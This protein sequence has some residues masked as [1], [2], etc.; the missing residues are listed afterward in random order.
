[1]LRQI[2]VCMCVCVC[3]NVC[4][5]CVS[6]MKIGKLHKFPAKKLE[7][8]FGRVYTPL[9][10]VPWIG[11]VSSTFNTHRVLFCHMA[12]TVWLRGVKIIEKIDIHPKNFPSKQ[13]HDRSHLKC[14]DILPLRTEHFPS[15]GPWKVYTS[16]GSGGGTE[17]G[18]ICAAFW[19]NRSPAVCCWR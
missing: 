19:N 5:L 11:T 17:Q 8:L 7:V 3:I 15:R 2:N 14:I 16:G 18:F 9:L 6:K 1:M 10:S 13:W 12:T 4:T